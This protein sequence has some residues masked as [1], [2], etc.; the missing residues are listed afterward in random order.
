MSD[1]HAET[2]A[3]VRDTM[4]EEQEPPLSQSGAYKWI[5][6]NMFSTPLNV[7]LTVVSLFVIW[8]VLSHL[9]PWAVMGIW[10]ADSLAQCREIRDEI[11]GADAS[12]ACWAVI[13]ERWKQLLFG[14]YPPEHYWRPVLAFVLFLVAISPVLF[15]SLPRKLLAFSVV[16]P[17]ILFWL[18][19]GG[20]IW[21]PI[22]VAQ[23]TLY[24]RMPQYWPSSGPAWDVTSNGKAAKNLITSPPE[25]NSTQPSRMAGACG[26]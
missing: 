2:V 21:G 6:E 22:C 18:I 9:L 17:F 4:V 19:W 8:T 3:F 24:C 5:H 1:T 7:I 23:P 13:S 26:C 14:F 11:Y 25:S 10:D 15:S 20:T 12:V 16:A